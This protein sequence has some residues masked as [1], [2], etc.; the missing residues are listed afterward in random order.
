MSVKVDAV[1]AG[2]RGN[3]G[4]RPVVEPSAVGVSGR[5]RAP[6]APRPLGKVGAKVWR[7]VWRC[8]ELLEEP[9]AQLVCLCAESFDEREQLRAFIASGR[10]TPADRRALRDLD[11]QIVS[12]LQSF[13]MSPS[14]RRRLNVSLESP[15][16]DDLAKF[17]ARAVL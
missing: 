5:R 7:E 13:G 10:S 6:R 4:K 9:D 1:T 17:R 2:R 8:N 12:L 16:V 15:V 14:D 11:K 3:P